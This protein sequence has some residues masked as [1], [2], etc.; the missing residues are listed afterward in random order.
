VCCL[1]EFSKRELRLKKT[2]REMKKKQK[3]SLAIALLA[4]PVRRLFAVKT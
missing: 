2:S 4:A 3:T 1:F